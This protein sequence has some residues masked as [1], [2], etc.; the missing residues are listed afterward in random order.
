MDKNIENKGSSDKAA[1]AYLLCILTAFIIMLI[2]TRSS[3]L[4]AF[5][6]WDDSNSYFTVGKSL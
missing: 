1:G 4:Y 3:P 2:C 6:N 5:N